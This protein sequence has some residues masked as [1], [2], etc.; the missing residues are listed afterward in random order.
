[1]K[2][3]RNLESWCERKDKIK[4]RYKYKIKRAAPK[5]SSCAFSREEQ[6]PMSCLKLFFLRSGLALGW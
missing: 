3:H 6:H 5:L 4:R 1:M 2:I